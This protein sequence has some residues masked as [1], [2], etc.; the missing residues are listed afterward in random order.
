M[1]KPPLEEGQVRLIGRI[2]DMLEL[3]GEPTTTRELAKI[4]SPGG[5]I[6]PEH[7]LRGVLLAMRRASENGKVESRS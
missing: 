3:L 6:L 2:W 1:S 7:Q 4:I 5:V